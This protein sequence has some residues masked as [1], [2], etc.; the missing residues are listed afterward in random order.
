MDLDAMVAPLRANVVSGAS[1]V[2]RSAAEVVRRAAVHV[3]ADDVE[4]LRERLAELVVKIL[5]AQPAM[6]PLVA[7]GASILRALPSAGSLA[8]ARRAAARAAEDARLT[9]ERSTAMVGEA[10]AEL[11]P[12][13]ARVLTLSSSSM[14]RAA[15]MEA[16]TDRDLEVICLESRPMNEGRSLAHGLAQQ[17]IPVVYAVDAAAGPLVDRST[18]VLLGADSVG[19]TG[20]VNKIGSAA[21]ACLAR[22]REVPVVVTAG[23]AKLLPPGFPQ[24][25]S[26]DRPADEVWRAPA[27]IQ[28]WNRYFEAVPLDAVHRVVVEDGG[29]SVD[30]VQALRSELD[31]PAELR[32][33]A[34][35]R[36]AGAEE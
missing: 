34:D 17:G 35:S 23:E 26:D 8:E 29:L 4:A 28:V 6:A 10:A 30:E 5:D 15:L 9:L 12:D 7:L 16:A 36:S 14:V 18:L 27:G 22:E 13:G 1:V 33:W 19:D 32:R 25:V 3:E 2:A 24:G 11:L 31:V 20:V 21:L